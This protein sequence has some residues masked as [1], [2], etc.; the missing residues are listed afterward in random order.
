MDINE[1]IEQSAGKWFSQRTSYNLAHNQADN[2]KADVTIEMIENG[3][4]DLIT[5]C[6]QQN[7][8]ANG[9]LRATRISWDNSV[10]WGKPKQTGMAHL[11]LIPDPDNTEVGKLIRAIAIPGQ[12]SK[13]G[14]YI[15]GQDLA[16]TL[17][18]EDDNTYFEERQ[19]FASP[20][21]RLRT[22]VFRHAEGVAH[23]SFYSE[24]RKAIPKEE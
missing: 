5:L 7:I 10:D 11:V 2:S 14:R 15:L 13:V 16:L 1:F 22:T 6:Q 23:T 12:T 20:N 3:D 24:I 4:R 18:V 17:I 19:W 21:L 8:S 9:N